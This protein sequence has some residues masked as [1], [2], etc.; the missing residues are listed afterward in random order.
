MC[1]IVY[2]SHYFSHG[3]HLNGESMYLFNCRSQNY[4]TLYDQPIMND[5]IVQDNNNQR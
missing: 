2:F 1:V 3:H 5:T 4:I